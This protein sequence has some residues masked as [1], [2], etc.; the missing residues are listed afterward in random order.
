MI[1]IA[2]NMIKDE[3]ITFFIK[4]FAILFIGFKVYPFL[5]KL[6]HLIKEGVYY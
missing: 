3:W 1:P 4:L 6:E 5:E 2:I